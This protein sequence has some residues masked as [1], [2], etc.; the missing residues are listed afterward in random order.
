LDQDEGRVEEEPG[1]GGEEG[2]EG[3]RRGG[4]VGI[5]RVWEWAETFLRR[6]GFEGEMWRVLGESKTNNS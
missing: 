2:E 6:R 4:G 5:Y 3:R 1:G